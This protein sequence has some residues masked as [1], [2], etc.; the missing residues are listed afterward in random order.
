[1]TLPNLTRIVD[2]RAQETKRRPVPDSWEPFDGPLGLEGY[3][4]GGLRVLLS[5]DRMDDG[6][7]WLHVSLSRARTLPTWEDLKLVK[8]IFVG[9]NHEAVQVLPRDEDYVNMMP[10]CLH[11]WSPE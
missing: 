7:R 11:L 6:Q 9:R 5:V 3:E 1:M 2:S 4:S 10:Y 8:D